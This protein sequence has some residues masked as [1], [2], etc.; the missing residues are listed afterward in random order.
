[1]KTIQLTKEIL[2][3]DPLHHVWR[4]VDGYNFLCHEA[5]RDVFGI[6]DDCESITLTVSK[7]AGEGKPLWFWLDDGDVTWG[8]HEND[9]E[10]P[11]Y[12]AFELW[13]CMSFDIPSL[14]PIKL[15]VNIVA[16]H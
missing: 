15:Y 14:D 7:E 3:E 12:C 11:L 1:M 13:L 9:C 6:P 16:D 5:V 2:R 10:R 4:S 8:E